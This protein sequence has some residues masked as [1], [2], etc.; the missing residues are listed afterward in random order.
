MT[1]QPQLP[2]VV[3]EDDNMSNQSVEGAP[4]SCFEHES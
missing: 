1:W 2:A 4:L 3:M